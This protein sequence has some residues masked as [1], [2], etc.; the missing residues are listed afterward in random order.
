VIAS[1][2]SSC[3]EGWGR[4]YQEDSASGQWIGAA[5]RVA[6]G[7]VGVGDAGW[8]AALALPGAAGVGGQDPVELA[9][10]ADAEL[11]EDLVQVVLERARAD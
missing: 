10:G 11:G 4:V 2:S 6:G 8:P 7:G 9:A 3:W 5:V 1:P